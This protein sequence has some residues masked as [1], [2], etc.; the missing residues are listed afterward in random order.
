MQ[1]L[2]THLSVL[3][4]GIV[5]EPLPF[6]VLGCWLSYNSQFFAYHAYHF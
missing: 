4:H 2:S 5:V 1:T 6:K 3:P